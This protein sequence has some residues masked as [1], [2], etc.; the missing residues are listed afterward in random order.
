VNAQGAVVV[1]AAGNSA[2]HAVG[3]PANCPGVIAVAGLRH[4]GTKVG[5]SD[6]GPEITVA[7]P[8]G[9][10]INISAGSPCLYPILTATNAGRTS[11]L[12]GSS[13]FSDAF[14]I[15]VGTSFATP[16]VAGTAALM[17][18]ARPSLTPAEVKALLRA[19]AR[20]FPTSGADNG[21]DDPTPV[22]IC[23]APTGADQL[24]CYCNTSLCGAGMLDAAGAV[25]AAQGLLARITV[26]P[27]APV[28]G[29]N[30]QLS[31]ADT[32]LA[33]G[34]TVQSW[35]W[36]LVNG[37]GVVSGF[38][39]TTNAATANLV[40]SGAGTVTVRLTVADDQNQT[41]TVDAT[42][43][44]SEAPVVQPP[45]DPGTGSAGGGLAAPAWLLGLLAAAWALRR[46]AGVA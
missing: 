30:V 26:S 8:G 24:Q 42:F 11:P 21:P 12:A 25:A 22:P 13:V 19:T 36:T 32:L 28:A 14:D 7:A 44:V 23:T 3:T 6:L 27:A 5:F 20:A 40:P 10:C 2:G 18:S 38:S 31:A 34:R 43:A 33:P 16:I 4:A 35:A 17:M 37:G 29:T 9:N 46:Q 39:S 41:S 15:S 1:A 45:P